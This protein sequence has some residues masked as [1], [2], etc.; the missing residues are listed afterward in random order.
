MQEQN[1]IQFKDSQKLNKE[2]WFKNVG[3]A[4]FIS[5]AAQLLLLY[6]VH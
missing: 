3:H 6:F 2:N 4:N 1:P 5:Y